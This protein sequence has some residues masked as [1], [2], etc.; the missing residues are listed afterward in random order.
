M[1]P[2]LLSQLNHRFAG[3]HY[4]AENASWR[5]LTGLSGS[6]NEAVFAEAQRQVDEFRSDPT[7]PQRIALSLSRGNL[8]PMNRVGLSGWQRYFA[9]NN[10]GNAASQ[11]LNTE[12]TD[13]EQ[14]LRGRRQAYKDGYVDPTSGEFT[15]KDFAALGNV[16]ATQDK[17][18]IRKA[19]YQGRLAVEREMI[20]EDFVK[21]VR[22][23]NRLARSLGYANYLEM[24]AQRYEG[25]SAAE[26]YTRLDAL[27][28]ATRETCRARMD[29]FVSTHGDFAREPWNFLFLT[30]GS[31]ERELDPFFQ[32]DRALVMWGSTLMGMGANY[33]QAQLWMDLMSRQGKSPNGFAMAPIPSWREGKQG[34]RW[35]PADIRFTSNV[36]PKQ[37]GSGKLAVHT[38]FHEGGH[39]LDFANSMM[40]GLSFKQEYPPTSIAFAE[41]HSGFFHHSIT[42]PLWL[43]RYPR[44]VD[45][46]PIPIPL[47]RA[48]LENHYRYLVTESR[49]TL[50]VPL[51]EREIYNLP[52]DKLSADRIIEI[53]RR[54]ESSMTFLNASPVPIGAITHIQTSQTT[55]YWS[56][57]LA[58]MGAQMTRAYFLNR[59]GRIVQN[60]RVGPELTRAYW[61][62]GN[63]RTLLENVRDLTGQ[64]FSAEAMI[65]AINKT[66]E[67]IDAEIERARELAAELPKQTGRI[68]LGASIL[69]THGDETIATNTDGSSFED[70][71]EKY[72][73]WI[74]AQI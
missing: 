53:F 5:L 33:A 10:W 40:P 21:I 70:M 6:N 67:Q 60:P 2:S 7:W 69:L 61:N 13:Q 49:R 17:E 3:L 68:E 22:L 30:K 18:A 26:I 14:S 47:L 38:L 54:A 71:V 41:M 36:T 43:L 65:A 39:A 37:V 32:F 57:T 9:S 28:V 34:K 15:E 72:D 55:P 29:A 45:G 52:D 48:Y 58:E 24:R 42:D 20:S 50:A 51:A 31:I 44:T 16:M 25:C 23:R 63:S 27:E 12:L 56:Y 62:P 11:A 35:H 19:A 46:E 64:E 8:L 1:P 59:Y 74:R 4:G 73:A 66:P